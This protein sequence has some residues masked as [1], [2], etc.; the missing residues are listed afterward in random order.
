MCFSAEASFIT[1]ASLSAVG[2]VTLGRVE[3]K[4]ELPFALIPLFFGIQQIIEGIVWLSFQFDAEA[5][6]FFM[7]NLYSL[8]SHVLWPIFLPLAV[9][10]LEPVAWRKKALSFFLLMGMIIGFYLLFFLIR[11]PITAQVIHHSISYHSPQFANLWV[12]LFYGAA[13]TV[14]CFFSSHRIVNVMGIL[15]VI[16]ALVAYWAFFASSGSV[17]CYFAA[18]ISVLVYFQIRYKEVPLAIFKGRT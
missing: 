18:I 9:G 13:T 3:R 11:S 12:V 1:G 2:A 16:S 6:N 4:E 5:V 10:L 14:T 7:V 8:F 15:L 17:W